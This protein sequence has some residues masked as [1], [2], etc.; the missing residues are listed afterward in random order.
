MSIAYG[1][2]TTGNIASG[3]SFSGPSVS[4]SNTLG[5]VAI[6]GGTSVVVSAI[7][8]G[9]T[10][11]TIVQVGSGSGMAALGYLKS[12]S[13]GGS[14]SVTYTGAGNVSCVAAY[15]TGVDQTNPVEVTGTNDQASANPTLSLTTAVAND[16]LV[17]AYNY[18]GGSP[19]AGSNTLLRVSDKL[20]DTNGDQAA[21]SNS[22]NVTIATNTHYWI[23][24][25]ALEPASAA[26]AT[27]VPRKQLLGVG[28]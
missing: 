19:V 24:G 10:S 1:A 25:L 4:G 5:V 15:Y 23:A 27:L 17:A 13:S 2:S 3:G 12:P 22:L 8:W 20:C 9:G 16:W 26:A 6:Q 28:I 21:G 14:V 7:T 18:N 11:M